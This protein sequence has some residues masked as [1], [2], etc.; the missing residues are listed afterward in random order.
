MARFAFFA[1]AAAALFSATSAAPLAVRKT[2]SAASSASCG[3][4]ADTNEAATTNG[5]AVTE[6]ATNF[7][8][9][10]CVN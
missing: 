9:L 8:L 5:T 3:T 6:S 7:Q 4:A 2:S 10:E 1:L